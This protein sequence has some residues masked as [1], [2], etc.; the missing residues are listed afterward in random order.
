VLQSVEVARLE[1]A[2]LEAGI[3]EVAFLEVACL[4]AEILEVA[5]LEVA[6]LEAGILE[7]AFLEV[8]FLEVAC[9]EAGI[10][11]AVPGAWTAAAVG[12][13]TEL[14]EAWQAVPCAGVGLMVLPPVHPI[15]CVL[16]QQAG[17]WR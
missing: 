10:F 17:H 8:A 14:R 12:V 7:V 6:C 5:R 13:R 2:C 16:K 4:E 1:V 11:V 15:G 3:L 9:L